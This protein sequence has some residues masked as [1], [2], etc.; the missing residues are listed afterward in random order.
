MRL[1]YAT[2]NDHNRMKTKKKFDAYIHK[3]EVMLILW[4]W[5]L[6][7]HLHLLRPNTV[8]YVCVFVCLFSISNETEK[9]REEED[10][11]INQWFMIQTQPVL[12]PPISVVQGG[13]GLW[14]EPLG[15]SQ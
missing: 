8:P 6:P 1:I 11:N 15:T 12:I 13:Y 10:K 5:K 4:R 7:N 14:S 3:F 9:K 2:R